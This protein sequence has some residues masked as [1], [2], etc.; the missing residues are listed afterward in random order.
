MAKGEVKTISIPDNQMGR[1]K[2]MLSMLN[3][4]VDGLSRTLRQN[5]VVKDIIIGQNK[6]YCDIKTIEAAIPENSEI[7]PEIIGMRIKLRY[8]RKKRKREVKG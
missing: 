2:F 4:S 1:F 3:L 5:G 8:K 6:K 7:D